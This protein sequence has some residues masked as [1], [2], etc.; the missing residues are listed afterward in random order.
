VCFLFPMGLELELFVYPERISTELIC[1]ICQGVV[2]NPVQ[3]P[4]EH[5]FCE[6][7]L[8]EWMLRSTLCPITHEPLDPETIKKPGRIISNM[9]SALERFCP[10]KDQGCEWSGPSDRVQAHLSEC[11]SHSRTDLLKKIEEKDILISLLRGKVAAAEN[12]ILNLEC[13]NESLVEQVELLTKK[14]KVYDAFFSDR[15]THAGT[16]PSSGDDPRWNELKATE[17]FKESDA[18]KLS[19]LRSLESLTPNNDT[20][21][22][23]KKIISL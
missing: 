4:S 1:P 6:E 5:L 21:S 15:H 19:R 3:T 2:E 12:R 22:A 23:E 8:L 11:Q 7:E 20:G 16:K 18:M 10:N 14:I 13:S 17:R 9:L